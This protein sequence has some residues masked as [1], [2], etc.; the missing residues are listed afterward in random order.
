MN[1]LIVSVIALGAATTAAAA[2][3]IEFRGAACLTSVSAACAPDGWSVGDCLLMRYSPPNIGTNGIGTEFSV[4]GQSFGAN[5]AIATGSLVGTLFVPVQGTHVGRTGYT[6]NS[7]MR[8]TSQSPVP[9]NT[10]KV[11]NLAGGISDFDAT[12]GCNVNFQASA[13]KRP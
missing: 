9:T 7:T 8:I 6:F 11:V 5:Y 2:Q 10:T 4:M 13:T 12:V 3:V 1:R